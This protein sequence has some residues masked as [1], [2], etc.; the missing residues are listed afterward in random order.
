MCLHDYQTSHI[1]NIC[2][3]LENTLHICLFDYHYIWIL[4]AIVKGCHN[5]WGVQQSSCAVWCDQWGGD[6]DGLAHTSWA[7]TVGLA[8]RGNFLLK[9]N[10]WTN[11]LPQTFL[12][13]T[14][15]G[16]TWRRLPSTSTLR[17]PVS[18]TGSWW[19]ASVRSTRLSQRTATSST[20]SSQM[21][22]SLNER[23]FCRSWFTCL[24]MD[25]SRWELWMLCSWFPPMG[26]LHSSTGAY[27]NMYYTVWL[28]AASNSSMFRIFSS[29]IRFAYDGEWKFA[30]LLTMTAGKLAVKFIVDRWKS[31]SIQPLQTKND[32]WQIQ[33]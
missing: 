6:H 24:A 28:V 7:W 26:C 19:S 25:T 32:I 2:V 12:S 21:R 20:S 5:R 29:N 13:R 4:I 30:D 1:S 3:P 18:W 14:P 9:I 22:R 15:G 27:Y 10:V 17:T 31:F 16:N 8:C 23:S 33:R 11:F